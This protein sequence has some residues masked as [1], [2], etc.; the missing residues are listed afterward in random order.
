MAERSITVRQFLVEQWLPT[1]E[2][3]IRPN[4]FVS[5]SS[6]LSNHVVAHLGDMRL[7][8][9]DG[10]VL[11]ALYAELM[12]SGRR[13]GAG[14]SLSPTTI[15][16]VHATLRRA[17]KDAVRWG[18]LEKNPVLSCDPPRLARNNAM[19][20]W[21]LEQLREFLRFTRSDE[22]RELW[23]L[24]AT[25][26][27]R[28]SEALGLRWDNVAL[29][30]RVVAIRQTLVLVGGSLHMSEP[31]SAR[32]RRVIVLDET[33]ADALEKLR[34]RSGTD[35]VFAAPDGSPLH[36]G[37]VSTRFRQLV[38]A[39]GLPKIRLHD[40]RH[41]YATLALQAGIHPKIVS[42]RLGH[43]TIALTLDVY[44]HALP[45]M[46]QEAADR[47]ASLIFEN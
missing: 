13:R 22:W 19:R 21:T 30:T 16:R 14:R 38:A 11:N 32:S 18:L 26:G 36:P 28:R 3:T 25:T 46:Q 1:I 41:T 34:R 45:T 40:L 5:Y 8:D 29:E 2:P 35:L 47:V 20:T 15:R 37:G 4:T 27:M 33:T 12:R 23:L 44:S 9:V 42:E 43:S 10:P 17:F 24:L 31:K 39:S 7:D 6:H